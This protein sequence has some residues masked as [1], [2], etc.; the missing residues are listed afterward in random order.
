MIVNRP[1]LNIPKTKM[2]I[3]H[4][5]LAIVILIASFAYAAWSWTSLPEKFPSH[6]DMSGN[7]N[8]WSG[9]GSLLL[10]PILNVVLYVG[11][12][13]LRRIPHHFNYI[14]EITVDNAYRQ[15][16]IALMM[17]SWIKII[18]VALFGYLEWD[19]IYAAFGNQPRFGLLV[20]LLIAL[21]GAMA[22]Y[23]AQSTKK[24]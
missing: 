4:D 20:I 14:K 3:C 23:I 9:K 11:L 18:I 1:V 5:I 15:Y 21:F 6:F 10:L 16:T 24:A 12:T 19:I 7:P 8:G 22:Y 13:L 2:E 17:V